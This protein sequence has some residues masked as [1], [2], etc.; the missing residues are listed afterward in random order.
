MFP[1]LD[2]YFA[3]PAQIL[4][5]AGEEQMIYEYIMICLRCDQMHILIPGNRFHDEAAG[6]HNIR[7]LVYNSAVEAVASTA[8]ALCPLPTPFTVYAHSPNAYTS[9]WSLP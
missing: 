7:Y 5:T 1:G 6:A 2:L 4:T 8:F 3:D 9:L